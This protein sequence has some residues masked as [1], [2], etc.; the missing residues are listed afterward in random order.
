[1]SNLFEFIQV[2]RGMKFMKNFKGGASN[3]SL[4]TS[5]QYRSRLSNHFQLSLRLT[6]LHSDKE[7]LCWKD[8][9]TRLA[10]CVC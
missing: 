5:A 3:K 9:Q 8:L 1:M 2:E 7:N 4:G 6:N 10:N